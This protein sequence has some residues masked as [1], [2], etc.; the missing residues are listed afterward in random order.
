MVIL[1]EIELKVNQQGLTQEVVAGIIDLMKDTSFDIVTIGDCS[2]DAFLEPHKATL[3]CKLNKKDCE[4]CFK[5]G[6]KIPVENLE[7]HTGG[8]AANTAVG[9]SRLGLK[10][11]IITTIGTDELSAKI[12]NTLKREKIDTNL[13]KKEAGTL[14][15]F[16]TIISFEGERTI[17]AYHVKRNHKLENLPSSKWIYLTSIGDR[18]QEVYEKA[19][20]YAKESN[21]KIA[22]SPGIHQFEDSAALRQAI[23]QA[24]ILLVNLDEAEKLAGIKTEPD[25]LLEKLQSFG[26]KMVSITDGVDG[27]W[28]ILDDGKI[29]KFG[30]FPCDVVEKTGAGDAYSSGF[31]SAFFYSL[32]ISTAASWGAVNAAS[33]IS[34]VGA[35]VGLL[36]KGEIEERIKKWT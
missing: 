2:I 9:F 17:F 36:T 19:C 5:Y 34:K 27:S 29:M 26:P 24:T 7:L 11:A 1:L 23:S 30:A 25:K 10:T 3:H 14:S 35:Q 22:L 20:S 12:I 8:G 16:S 6:D 31:M 33:V 4:I 28:A 15:N 13:V 21:I 32:P 18:W